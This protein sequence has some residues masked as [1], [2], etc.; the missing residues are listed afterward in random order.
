[1]T[2]SDPMHQLETKPNPDPTLA[3]NAGIE[4]AMKSERD[5]ADG[6][7]DIL[8]ARLDANDKATG[9]RLATIDNMPEVIEKEVGHLSDLVD[10]KM[11]GI[12]E[13]F[14]LLSARTAEQKADNT[15]AL[16]DAL[17]AAKERVADQTASSEKSITKSETATTERIKGVEQLLATTS[18]ATD[19]KIGDLKDR[20]VAME[21]SRAGGLEER[22]EHRA[23][24]QYVWLIIGGIVGLLGLLI[25]AI[26]IAIALKPG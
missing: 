7:I 24:N 21:A 18:K 5:Y 23:G 25:A 8:V 13:Q 20:I 15:K 1:M 16:T 11:L 2:V 12:R 26:G 6:Q 3:T 10:E 17:A 9:I 4:R 14:L 22:G 19:D